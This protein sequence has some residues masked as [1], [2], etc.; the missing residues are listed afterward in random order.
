MYKEWGLGQ[1]IAAGAMRGRMA[2]RAPG[3]I[4]V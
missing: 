3:R 1:A 2:V 4:W